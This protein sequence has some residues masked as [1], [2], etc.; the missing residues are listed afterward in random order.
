MLKHLVECSLRPGYVSK[1][2]CD[3]FLRCLSDYL[4]TKMKS[5]LIAAEDFS[6]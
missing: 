6:L 1:M 4:G 5:R 2:S 3:E